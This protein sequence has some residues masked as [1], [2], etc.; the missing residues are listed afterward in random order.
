[1]DFGEMGWGGMDWTD[2]AYDRDPWRA[3]V[4]KVMNLQVP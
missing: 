1:M 3:L 4:K 2:L